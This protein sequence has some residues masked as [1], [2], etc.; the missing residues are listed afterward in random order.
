MGLLNKFFGRNQDE[1]GPTDELMNGDKFW[2]IIQKTHDTSG[3]NFDAQQTALTNSLMKMEPREIILFDNRFRQLRGYA[4]T[5]KLLGA[6]YLI[7]QGCGD[8]SFIDFRDWLIA[9]GKEFFYKTVEDPDGL[10]A[11]NAADIPI[12]MEGMSYI[13]PDVF[14]ELTDQKMPAAYA[15]NQSIKGRQW[16]DENDDLKNLL[17]KLWTKYRSSTK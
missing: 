17:P 16:K 12:D 5:W 2:T 13:A 15:E 4:Y 1:I 3:G 10:V 6:I 7:H 9:Q 8:D 14:E 11:M